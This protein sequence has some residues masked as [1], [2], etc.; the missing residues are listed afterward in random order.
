MAVSFDDLIPQAGS[1]SGSVT[2]DDLI[3]AQQA[4]STFSTTTPT[5][6]AVRL[7]AMAGSNA[8][9]GVGSLLS[10]PGD[11]AQ[12]YDAYIGAPFSR[13][14]Q[15]QS[16]QFGTV[17]PTASKWLSNVLPTSSQ[18]NSDLQ[19]AGIVDR[20]DLQPQNTGEKYLAAG[21][22][23]LGG[24]LPLALMSGGV[25]P[26]LSIMAQGAGSGVGSQAAQDIAPDSKIAPLLGAVAGGSLAGGIANLGQHAASAIGGDTS[27]ILKAYQDA[28]I[29]PTLVGDVSGD[30]AMQQ[31]QAF[32]SKSMGA[33]RIK[34]AS[35]QALG[36]FGNSVE[37]TADMFGNAST[38]QEAGSAI[39]NDGKKWLANWNNA[40]QEAWGNVNKLIGDTTP[41]P[42]ANTSEALSTIVSKSQGNNALNE[43]LKSP[44]AQS[45]MN[46]LK[47]G[48]DSLTWGQAS[49]L[50]SHVGQMLENPMLV[51]G[52]EQAQA[53]MLYGA[54]TNDMKSG[55]FA[56]GN[57]AALDAFNDANALT[58]S[59]H[60]YIEN[61]LGDVM[62]ANPEQAAK[63]LLSS[64]SM[65]G[66]QLQALRQQMPDAADQLAATAIRRM[67]AGESN[68][69]AGNAVS[70]SR[71]LSNQDPTR[72]MS[73]EAYQ[74]LFANPQA[75]QKMNAL[76]T[77]AD[78]MRQ[79]EKFVNHSNTATH[80]TIKGIIEGA[81]AGAY[82]GHEVGGLP[83]MLTGAAIG[84]AA[85]PA[86][87]YA[88]G[89]LSTNPALA[90]FMA[91][92]V[93]Q[94][95]FGMAPSLMPQI[96]P[97]MQKMIPQQAP[98]AMAPQLTYQQ[99]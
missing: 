96:S 6:S 9:K 82:M 77:V 36:Q 49:A 28:G 43:L 1:S 89:A 87:G 40:K 66:T 79:T 65:G 78:S 63:S 30:P 23:A 97:S 55:A 5:S 31:L 42:T 7:A 8:V 92:P 44:V 46:V 4:N 45:T 18:T 69:A 70:P 67:G 50:R 12:A 90:R 73:P 81:G 58:A 26:A 2:F 15:G 37:K 35:E 98:F 13:L 3:P 57:R 27:P 84:G 74:A 61:V 22:S 11:L 39:Q 59:G 24:S 10:T 94:A 85:L 71:W 48:N 95:P 88:L 21:S 20:P 34:D 32:A 54:L 99:R 72:K 53:K 52:P 86:S 51:S 83:G 38:L 76:D 17:D 93:T 41:I 75:Q 33:G 91:S 56:T 19:Q 64:A 47:D 29:K 62:K 25:A 68:G 80:G 60:D 16:P 14:V